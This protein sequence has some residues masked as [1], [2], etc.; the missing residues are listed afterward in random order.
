[1]RLLLHRAIMHYLR[2]CGGAF[3]HGPY[4]A[5]GSYVVAMDEAGYADL[6]YRHLRC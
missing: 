6:H 5:D 3:H 2:R 4:G 1:M